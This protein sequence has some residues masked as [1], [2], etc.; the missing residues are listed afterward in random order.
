MGCV[1]TK[2]V[3]SPAVDKQTSLQGLTLLASPVSAILSEGKMSKERILFTAAAKLCTESDIATLHEMLN[4][5][6]K[7]VGDEPGDCR[8]CGQACADLRDVLSAQLRTTKVPSRFGAQ[9]PC[10]FQE[11][12]SSFVASAT[13]EKSSSHLHAS[14]CFLRMHLM[15]VILKTLEEKPACKTCRIL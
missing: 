14:P 13:S 6:Q 7:S 1:E 9:C 11:C 3:S 10:T 12:I 4:L 5:L 8:E 15:R 2:Y